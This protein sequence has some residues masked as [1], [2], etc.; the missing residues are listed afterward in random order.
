MSA[1][2]VRW[3]YSFEANGVRTKSIR[4]YD[5]EANALLAMHHA[6]VRGRSKFRV[7]TWTTKAKPKVV[8][9]T[10]VTYVGNGACVCCHTGAMDVYRHL[11][12]VNG[13]RVRITLEE[14]ADE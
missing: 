3:S 5:S 10:S 7:V 2:T 4:R 11:H 12:G 6:A 9:K 14:L 13:K 1:P 8:A